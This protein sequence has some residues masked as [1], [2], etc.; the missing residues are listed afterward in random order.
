MIPSK[1]RRF[2]QVV[3]H[4]D[5]DIGP[6]TQAWSHTAEVRVQQQ[7]VVDD[8]DQAIAVAVA[9]CSGRIDTKLPNV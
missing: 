7:R 9:D 5:F 2:H 1:R 4:E 6:W 8:S 3:R